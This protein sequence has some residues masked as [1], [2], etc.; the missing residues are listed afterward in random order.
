MCSER[1]WFILKCL[2]QRR[3][4]ALVEF[5]IV[6]PFLIFFLVFSFYAFLT[7]C[8]YLAL[9]QMTREALRQASIETGL[10]QEITQATVDASGFL[11]AYERGT[12]SISA[13]V[14]D[15]ATS[16]IG[17]G[18]GTV[19]NFY[20]TSYRVSVTIDK[21]EEIP[22]V[23]GF[24]GFLGEDESDGET[25]LQFPPRQLSYTLDMRPEQ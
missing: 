6:F 2:L 11:L 20:E 17:P 7:F 19:K 21:K 4:Q 1:A 15:T 22:N 3:G 18:N 12:V 8:D 25:A 10:S 13:R 24:M 9:Q 5:I 16:P 23:L 14:N